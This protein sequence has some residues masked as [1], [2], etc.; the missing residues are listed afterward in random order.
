MHFYI[1]KSSAVQHSASKCRIVLLGASLIALSVV[2]P[3]VSRAQQSARVPQLEEIT[4]TARKQTETAI[5]TPVILTG[6]SKAQIEQRSITT[7]DALARVVPTLMSGIGGGTTQGGEIAL[8]GISGQDVN[9]LADQA[10]SFNLDGVPIA[11][12]T[13]R[14]LGQMDMAQIEVLEG[15]QA[16]YYGRNSPGGIISI[17]TADPT[18]KFEA[19]GTAGYDFEADEKR[20]EGYVSGPLTDT[21]GGRFSAYVSSMSGWMTNATPRGLPL[22]PAH[23]KGPYDT[24]YALRGTL[25]FD[26]SDR[27]SA[28]FKYTYSRYTGA[29]PAATAQI[30]FCPA[31]V[32]WFGAGTDDCTK[33]G[34][35]Y[36]PDIGTSFTALDGDFKDG[37]PY[38]HLQQALSS[39]EMNYKLTDQLTATSVTGWYS[40]RENWTDSFGVYLPQT[41]LPSEDPFHVNQISEEVRLTSTF[42]GPVNFMAGGQYQ[43]ASIKSGAITYSNAL[44]PVM[45]NRYFVHQT[46]KSW[47]IFGQVRWN[48]L[49]TLELSGGA[50]YSS[51]TKRLPLVQSGLANPPAPIPTVVP[52]LDHNTWTNTSPE[53]TLAWRPT[54]RLT[55]FGSYKTGFL[56]GGF[57][58]ATLNVPGVPAKMVYDQETIKGGEFGV[59]TLTLNGTLRANVSAY[60]YN[61]GGL[62]VT[63]SVQ[64]VTGP[65]ASVQLVTNAASAKIRGIE[66]NVE[67]A[68][69]NVDGLTVRGA[70][71]YNHARY[72]VYQAVC[73]RGQ[74]IAAGCNGG[75]PVGGNFVSQNLNG[76]Q[77]LRAPDWT[78]S[79]GYTY[80]REIGNNYK[81]SLSTDAR[82]SSSYFTEGTNQP[83]ARQGSYM[84]LD[85]NINFGQIDDRWQIALIGTNITN[86]Y[87][88]ERGGTQGST[89]TAPGNVNSRPGDILSWINRTRMIMLQV[90]AKTGG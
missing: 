45:A 27:F 13:V 29:G 71:D 4:V 87:V 74:S 49:P 20:F 67:Y 68:V 86:A 70:I 89:G 41:A 5:A 15:P 30:S 72:G 88:T 40:L 17:K 23:T 84:M 35:N 10:V 82:F 12:A 90:S 22:S 28:R 44:A 9:P 61:I 32:P 60:I 37:I 83:L 39:L 85:A 16:L 64:P 54:D 33:N 1:R 47:S 11:L 43:D 46:D 62:Q 57:N 65:P 25:K 36:H 18:S 26:P 8:R 63:S 3:Q 76:Q 79:A 42:S 14:F 78:G 34:V 73:W 66:G 24:E 21:L 56:S 19:K 52:P 55:V 38:L 59:K 51:E 31:G 6:V 75:I 69:P 48:I 58:S 50:R 2:N 7:I 81:M 53:A 80:T 77:L